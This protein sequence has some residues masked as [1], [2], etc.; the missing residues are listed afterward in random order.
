MHSRQR[1]T[2]TLASSLLLATI[3]CSKPEEPTRT[4]A[5]T[6]PPAAAPAP[7]APAPFRIVGINLGTAITADKKVAA[8]AAAFAPADTIYASVTT[9]GAAASVPL[10]ARWTY[11]G[12][13]LVNETSQSIAPTGPAA[14]EFHIAKPDGWPV[15]KYK[16]EISANGTVAATKEFVVN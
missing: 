14:F 8:P 12:D 9:D 7:P 10:K 4:S 15:G 5:P 13:Q 3:A 11:E 2:A 1:T 16:V 6:P